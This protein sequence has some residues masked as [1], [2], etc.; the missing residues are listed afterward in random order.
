MDINRFRQEFISYFE[1]NIINNDAIET[2][3]ESI[4]Y[5]P[6]VTNKG[7]GIGFRLKNVN[8][9]PIFYAEE[10]MK[11][12]NTKTI[13]EIA[14]SV[15]KQIKSFKTINMTM[16]NVNALEP[17]DNVILTAMPKTILPTSY[18]LS[19]I[20]YEK[21]DDVGLV[22]FL[23]TEIPNSPIPMAYGHVRKLSDTDNKTEIIKRAQFNTL[24][25]ACLKAMMTGSKDPNVPP[26]IIIY[27][28]YEFADY[29]YLVSDSI[30]ADIAKKNGFRKMY[31][32][33]NSAY[34]VTLIG[35]PATMSDEYEAAFET[36]FSKLVKEYRNDKNTILPVLEY[37][38]NNN[39]FTK[40]DDNRF[41]DGEEISWINLKQ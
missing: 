11:S 22:V 28:E 12:L 38:V 19:D 10:L 39:T 2:E 26:M 23:K 1:N 14:E 8:F 25:H 16:Q 13:G 33:S 20:E 15:N 18:G 31:V 21:H 7:H 34:S 6:T 3:V 40:V 41:N 35:I 32:L 27:D 36:A 4:S 9:G 37:N 17:D 30:L 24:R 29:F 5:N